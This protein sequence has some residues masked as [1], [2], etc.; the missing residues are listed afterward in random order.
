M[1]PS[2]HK[3]IDNFL[4]KEY[5]C[6]AYWDLNIPTFS[7]YTL[8]FP[9]YFLIFSKNKSI[10]LNWFLRLLSTINCLYNISVEK[11][12]FQFMQNKTSE[13]KFFNYLTHQCFLLLVYWSHPFLGGTCLNLTGCFKQVKGIHILWLIWHFY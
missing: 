4:P 1:Y 12:K 6:Q 11:K 8:L 13:K 9:I 3:H 5:V 10:L 7:W 2:K